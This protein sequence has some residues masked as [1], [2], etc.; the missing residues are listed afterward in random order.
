[1][2][3]TPCGSCGQLKQRFLDIKDASEY[4]GLSKAALRSM[5]ARR[6]IDFFKLGNRIRFDISVLKKIM[7]HYPS[8]NSLLN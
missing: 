2:Q 5:V 8:I 4:L 3:D 6:E 7:I 1:M